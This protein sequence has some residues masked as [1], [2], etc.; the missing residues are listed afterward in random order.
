MRNRMRPRD[1]VRAALEHQ[2]VDRTPIDLGGTPNSTMCAGAY[3]SFKAFLGVDAPSRIL[4]QGFNTIAMDDAVLARLPVD[5]RGVFANPPAR[6]KS[7]WLDG[8][9]FVGDWGIT[10][11]RPKTWTQ[12]DMIAHPLAEAIIDDLETYDWPDV[13]DEG[14]Y[15]G[16]RDRARDLHQN[17]DYAI[18][19]STGDSTIFDTAW[20]LRG[21]EQFLKDLL[22]DPE[23][24]QALLERVMQLQMRRHERFLEQVG[25]YIDVLMI[26]DDLGTQNGLLISPKLY[27]K[28]VK[29][30]HSQYVRFVKE[31]T[32]AKVVMHACGSIADLVEDYIEIGV[33]ALNPM[34]ITAANMS[35]QNLRDRFGGRIAFWGGIDTQELLPCGSPQDVRRAVRNTIHIMGLSEGGYVLGAVHNVQDDVPPENVWTMLD[36]AATIYTGS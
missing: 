27:R 5:T 28:M 6:S 19:G 7:C 18:C 22:L 17:T 36:E 10:Y 29:P 14:R 33:D 12:L 16:L 30:L 31:R 32:N 3:E 26:S 11:R 8:S 2:E 1:R 25:Q 21:M 34:Q 20:M 9:T 35:P 4:S 23:F 13:D 15:A 24:A